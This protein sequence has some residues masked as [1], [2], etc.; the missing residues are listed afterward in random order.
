MARKID[1]F[2]NYVRRLRGQRNVSL[3]RFAAQVGISATYLSKVERG[4][5]PPPGEETIRA[6]AIALDKNADAFLAVAGRI[7]SELT[8]VVKDTQA[9]MVPFL[10]RLGSFS[11]AKK[12]AFLIRFMKD[13]DRAR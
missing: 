13:L 1:Q 2:G 10:R 5:L 11:K 9:E 6:I 12:K 7:P 4:D 8:E 3:R